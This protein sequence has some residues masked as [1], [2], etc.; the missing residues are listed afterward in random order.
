[1]FTP[2][3]ILLED[4]PIS[5]FGLVMLA[6]AGGGLAISAWL[7]ARQGRDAGVLL[8]L[9]VWALVGAIVAG[10]LFYIWN[11]PPSVAVFYNRRWFLTHVFDLQVGPLAVWNGGFGRA[12][13]LLGGVVGVALTLRRGDHDLWAWADVLT[14]GTLV[15]LAILP[16]ANLV[17]G[18]LLG[19]PTTLPW[20]V[21]VPEGMNL[22]VAQDVITESVRLHP[23]PAY[24]S[25]WAVIVLAVALLIRKRGGWF[26][27]GWQSVVA[28]G[29]YL[30][31]L[32]WL[33]FLRL[34]VSR[35]LLGLTGLQVICA[36]GAAACGVLVWRRWR[37]T[38]RPI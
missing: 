25:L 2:G 38:D 26:G 4:F 14:P 18:Q 8:D 35:G 21:P 23:T 5:P 34:D 31:G 32:F 15:M 36:L 1:M 33:D 11:P 19:P 9:A 20:G 6:A 22:A 10:R 17:N 29:L 7:A 3:G 27:P 24:A 12:G 37:K 30:T 13:L 28:A 16:W